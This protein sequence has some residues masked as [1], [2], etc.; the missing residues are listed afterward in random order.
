[1]LDAPSA[2]PSTRPSDAA[3]ALS[4]E[5]KKAGNAERIISFEKSLK[6]LVRPRM[7]MLRLRPKRVRGLVDGETGFVGLWEAGVGGIKLLNEFFQ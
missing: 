2:I 6:K 5:V 1:M 4:T 7:K 3:P